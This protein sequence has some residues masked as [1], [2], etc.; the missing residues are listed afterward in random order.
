MGVLGI[1]LASSVLHRMEKKKLVIREPNTWNNFIESYFRC[2][3]GTVNYIPLYYISN[4]A[5]TATK[6]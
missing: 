4:L 6:S 2:V 1:A 3:R 5:I